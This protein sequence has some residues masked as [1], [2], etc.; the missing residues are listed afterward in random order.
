MMDFK[1]FLSRMIISSALRMGRG[2]SAAAC[3][4]LILGASWSCSSDDDGETSNTN[5]QFIHSTFA[6]A[7]SPDWYVD[8]TASDL[9]PDWQEPES[10]TYECSMNMLV[11]LA[12]ELLPLS[13]DDDRMAIFINGDCRGVSERNVYASNGEIVFL[14]HA[15][16]S[17]EEVGRNM[18]MR[19]YSGGA[20]QLFLTSSVPVFTPNNII[21]EEAFS[22]DIDPVTSSTKFPYFTELNVIL[23]N[24][25][26]FTVTDNDQMAIFVGDECR[27]VCANGKDAYTGWKGTVSQR[28]EN[29]QAHVR[30]YSAEKGG[31]YILSE[32]FTLNGKLQHFDATF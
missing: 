31:I 32:P 19:Y 10:Y 16:G 8:W 12:P 26:P 23:P 1:K 15:K 22:I 17:D 4:L 30:Y 27:G 13:T 25:L 2:M 18:E 20:H 3:C 28:Q 21:G 24:E 9:A 6:S 5:P 11:T 7:E 29:E 14:I